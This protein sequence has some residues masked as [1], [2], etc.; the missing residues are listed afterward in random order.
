MRGVVD[1]FED[2]KGGFAH[3]WVGVEDGEGMD[4][5][6]W[7]GEETGEGVN[8]DVGFQDRWDGRLLGKDEG[9]IWLLM[10]GEAWGRRVLEKGVKDS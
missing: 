6:G 10:R 1:G 2:S 7:E 8:R 5:E 9:G 3:I 4:C